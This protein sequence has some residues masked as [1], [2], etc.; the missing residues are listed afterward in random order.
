MT[1]EEQIKAICE[2]Y[3]TNVNIT[4]VKVDAQ[5]GA[6]ADL[7]RIYPIFITKRPAFIGIDDLEN[8]AKELAAFNCEGG[9]IVCCKDDVPYISFYKKNE[10]EK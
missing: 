10:A 6:G 5:P 4:F 3:F 8:L 2:K 1:E 9:V 7:L